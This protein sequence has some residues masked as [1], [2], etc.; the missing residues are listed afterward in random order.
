MNV[1]LL[2]KGSNP[3]REIE[4]RLVPT[5]SIANLAVGR[6]SFGTVDASRLTLEQS[7]YMRVRFPGQPTGQLHGYGFNP[8]ASGCT[9]SF[10]YSINVAGTRVER[11]SVEIEWV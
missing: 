7:T 3:P 5:G 2:I 1:K 9:V 11:I 10:E 4:R 8:P 6:V